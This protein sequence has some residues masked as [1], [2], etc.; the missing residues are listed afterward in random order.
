[1]PFDFAFQISTSFSTQGNINS[2]VAQIDALG[3]SNPRLAVKWSV[4]MLTLTYTNDL[5]PANFETIRMLVI[6]ND[7]TSNPIN[8]IPFTYE[9]SGTIKASVNGNVVTYLGINTGEIHISKD[10]QRHFST[11]KEATDT[12][13]AEN[14]V[15]IVHPGTY[16][17]QNPIILRN[18]CILKSQGIFE[19]TIIVANNPSVNLITLG[20]QCLLKGLTIQGVKAAQGV[21]FNGAASG[22]LGRVSSIQECAFKDCLISIESDGQNGNG[23]VDTLY[24]EKTVIKPLTQNLSIGLFVHSKG[25]LVSN[26]LSVF[27]VPGY[28][29][30]NN[31]VYCTDTGSKLTILTN[32]MWFLGTAMLVDNGGM[33]EIGLITAGYCNVG[34]EVGSNGTTSQ[35]VASQLF[36]Q[37]SVSW[38]MNV[39]ASDASIS[40][41]SGVMNDTKINNPNKITLNT[42]YHLTRYG[43]F[44]QSMT[45]NI[46]LGSSREPSKLYA[47]EGHYDVDHVYILSNNN[48]EIG[49]FIDNTEGALSDT[50]P[51]FNM[52]QSTGANNCL[53]LGKQSN[54]VGFK[55]VVLT[56]AISN[57]SQNDMVY[58]YWNGSDWIEFTTCDFISQ[59]PYYMTTSEFFCEV[60]SYHVNFGLTTATPFVT[61]VIGGKSAKW[62]RIRIVNAL[63]SVPILQMLKPHP[64]STE[65]DS[66]GFIRHFGDSRTVKKI[67]IDYSDCFEMVSPTD[68][69][70]FVSD[71]LYIKRIKN[72]FPPSVS[73]GVSFTTTLPRDID[74]S[75]PLKLSISF[76]GTSGS[77]NVFWRIRYACIEIGELVY[78]NALDAPTVGG[79]EKS[80]AFIQTVTTSNVSNVSDIKFPISHI[81]VN[82]AGAGQTTLFVSIERDG[83][84][85]SDTYNGSANIYDVSLWGIT[86]CEGTHLLGF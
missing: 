70:V 85:L 71:N 50:S 86:W 69:Q 74:S 64:N 78:T 68:Q 16:V 3:I 12:I 8:I 25:I 60:G 83:T 9:N 80:T 42:I 51:P 39:L 77:G 63:P 43:K 22:G 18:G 35:V 29:S 33:L 41:H 79:D 45:G 44:Y 55:V 7:P 30:I 19:N 59:A 21:Y 1:M 72:S 27:G 11:I 34:L 38:D 82:K 2:L 31:G 52:F 73:S 62:I 49:T 15:F 13:I 58:E 47:G 56:A 6:Q 40:I 67:S 10:S 14:T 53:Y 61:K 23:I 57:V 36:I 84:N 24:C 28:F 65:I 66:D 75:F 20:Y 46:L 76:T 32:S 17:E 37:N 5:S 4:G 26:V 54:I 81:L 48:L